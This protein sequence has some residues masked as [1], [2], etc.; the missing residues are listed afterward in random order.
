MPEHPN[1]S[2]TEHA[3]AF[4]TKAHRQ[5]GHRRKLSNK[6]HEAYLKAVAQLVASVTD[7]P[8]MIAAAWLHD[9][10]EDTPITVDELEQRFGRGVATL[11][12]ELSNVSRPSD[13]DRTTRAAKDL[14]H[15][16]Q[17]SPR[18]KTIKL[19][20]LIEGAR[21]LASQEPA[22][23]LLLIAEM[24]SLLQ[25]LQEGAPRLLKQATDVL[26]R[27][28]KELERPSNLSAKGAGEQ[29]NQLPMRPTVTLRG[30]LRTLR[31]F[32]S[33][34][35]A[36][37]LAKPLHWFDDRDDLD[38]ISRVMRKQGI[39][40]A[41][42]LHQGEPTG[43]WSLPLEEEQ[44]ESRPF[45]PS[46]ILKEDAPFSDVIQVL[47]RYRWCFVA[48]SDRILAVIGRSDLQKP[49]VRMWLFGILTAMEIGLTLRIRETWPDETWA[50]LLTPERL[51]KAQSI[52]TERRRR[53]QNPLLIDCLQFGDKAA[54]ALEH[55]DLLA[56][57]VAQTKSQAKKFFSE[58]ESLR[59]NL[60]HAQDFVEQDW[61]A[62]VRINLR[63]A[64]LIKSGKLEAFG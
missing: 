52:Q 55:T 47:T 26:H 16:Q 51:A 5:I 37:Q 31:R 23:A 18:A 14:A 32:S 20:T 39:E 46:Q 9:C 61:P 34:F 10:V 11:L 2:L 48:S 45:S 7:D 53:G 24:Q 42:L 27:C 41:G 25:A 29:A 17:A 58:I 35:D 36:S 12:E 28:A 56:L 1:P 43:Y 22:S 49:L 4:A 57:T 40:V 54:L 3:K 21:G 38:T 6:P 15:L 33:L 64:E 8:E 19:A 60:A 13:G 59:N 50:P 30:D 44:S 62:I 63:V